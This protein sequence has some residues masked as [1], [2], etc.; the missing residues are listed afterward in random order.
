MQIKRLQLSAGPL[1]YRESGRGPALVLLHGIS[2]G[3]ASWEPL[4][5]HLPDY[6]LLAWDAPGYGQSQP[7]ANPCPNAAD[8]VQRLE[9]WRQALDLESFVLVG[10]S[11]G[12]MVAAAYWRAYPERLAG[13]VLASPAAG[14]QY[15]AQE[16][17]TAVYRS[18]FTQ[19]QDMGHKA[20]AAARAPHLLRRNASPEDIARVQAG[21][22]R[23]N[24]D[25]FRQASWMLAEDAIANYLNT[26][27]ALPGLVLCGEEDSITPPK[28]ARELAQHLSLPYREIRGAGHACYIDAPLAF[29]AAL[30]GFATREKFATVNGRTSV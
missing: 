17:R 18:R 28:G 22:E 4:A 30:R 14:Y 21:I 11:L 9:D 20:Y 13:L 27:L 10:H 7:L 25:G 23:L 12:A 6:R 3:A 26:S 29:A 8:Y 1:Y 5:A 15:A 24:I 19:L 16:K 2:S